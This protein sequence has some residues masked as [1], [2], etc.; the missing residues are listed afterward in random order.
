MRR[1]EVSPSAALRSH[2]PLRTGPQTPARNAPAFKSIFLDRTCSEAT[3]QS[4]KIT[5]NFCKIEPLNIPYF[6]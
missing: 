1:G 5:K 2:L 4:I 3:P 6:V